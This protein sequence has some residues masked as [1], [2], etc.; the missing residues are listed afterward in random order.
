M[1]ARLRV[2]EAAQLA[3]VSP[4][5]LRAWESSGLITPSRTGRY[6]WF[7]QRDVRDLQ[8]IA[9]LRARGFNVAAIRSMLRGDQR[10][11][12]PPGDGARE[13]PPVAPDAPRRGGP[14]GA[15][16]L[17]GG[18]LEQPLGEKLRAA[19]HRRA[20][21]LRDASRL[22]GLS[23]SHLSAIECGTRNAS[24][25]GLQRLAVALGI[26]V[27]DLFGDEQRPPRRLVRA[28]Q[29]PV[30][31]TGDR[32]VRIESLSV[33]AQLLEP[34]MYLVEPGGGSQGSYH[35]DGEETVYVLE[36]EVEFWLNE[37]E[38]H[39]VG[40][41]LP[42]L[43]EQPR[44]PVA[45]PWPRPPGDAVGE[46]AHHVLSGAAGDRSPGRRGAQPGTGIS[47]HTPP[48]R[49]RPLPRAWPGPPS[50]M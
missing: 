12:G 50:P 11:G 47:C 45:E 42:D 2:S 25:A 40:T 34:H 15:R 33:G 39:T 36:G 30:L 38:R 18:M 14:G 26:G 22:A 46:H 9:S 16:G 43:P 37:V 35:H 1:T 29:R 21:S 27:S 13:G 44:A 31:D 17:P 10:R 7:S 5:T 4:S 3:G 48:F 20:L 23:V 24:L 6:R 32:R 28:G 19:R 41:G 8:E 49:L